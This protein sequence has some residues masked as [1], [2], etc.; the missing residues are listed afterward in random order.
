[1]VNGP[2]TRCVLFVSGCVHKCKG[3]YNATTWRADSGKP[4]TQ[5]VEDQIIADLQDRRIKRRGL[6]LSGGDPLYPGNIPAILKL[7]KRVREQCPGKDI[8][9]WTGYRMD[10]LDSAQME[11]VDLLDVLID[12]RFVEEKKDL[13]LVWRGSSNQI[14]HDLRAQRAA[15]QHVDQLLKQVSGVSQEYVSN[16]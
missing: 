3:C 1:M 9:A 16:E 13:S 4:F 11:V 15:K 5:E 8:W 10:E 14:V 7:V 12:G 6:S 2:G